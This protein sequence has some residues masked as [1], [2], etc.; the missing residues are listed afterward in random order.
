MGRALA[1]VFD[2][3]V[4]DHRLAKRRF[5]RGGFFDL[6]FRL[7]RTGRNH[8]FQNARAFRTGTRRRR[9]VAAFRKRLRIRK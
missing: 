5:G 3:D 1:H 2:E 6:E 7:L 9:S 4:I 8:A